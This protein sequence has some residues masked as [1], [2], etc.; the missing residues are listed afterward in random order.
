[1]AWDVVVK[2]DRDNAEDGGQGSRSGSKREKLNPRAVGNT[3]Q[4]F[5][6]VVESSLFLY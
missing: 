5:S 1:M 6:L 3:F 4:L 2:R